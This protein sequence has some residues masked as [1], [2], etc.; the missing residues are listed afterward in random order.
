MTRLVVTG[1][2]GFLGRHVVARGLSLGHEVVAVVRHADD[3]RRA[4]VLPSARVV[5]ADLGDRAALSKALEG[6]ELVCHCAAAIPGS[7]NEDEF[8]ASNVEGTSNLVDAA[9]AEGVRR[10]VYVSSDS[11]YGDAGTSDAVEDQPLNPSYF[12]E[13]VYPR[14]KLEGEHRV[15]A[16]S[17]VGRIES[18]IVRTCL[19]IGPGRSPGSSFLRYWAGVRVHPLWG[20]GRARISVADVDDVAAAVL[21]AATLPAA[22]NRIYNV[23]GERPVAWRD[24]VQA[25]AEATGRR[26]RVLALPGTAALPLATLLHRAL[27][28]PAPRWARRFDPMRIRFMVADHAMDIHRIRSELGYRPVWSLGESVRRTLSAPDQSS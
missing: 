4:G 8:W 21:L 16:A 28:G 22:A 14:S 13:G 24:I 25:I 2:A 26:H 20:G 17:R 19:L 18:V 6:A 10:L 15:L 3:A 1:A 11:V 9:M 27:S 23:S 5:Q 7:A 12:D